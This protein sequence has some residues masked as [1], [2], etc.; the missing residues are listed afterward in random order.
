MF[1]RITFP[2]VLLTISKHFKYFKSRPTPASSH[3]MAYEIAGMELGRHSKLQQELLQQTP[4]TNT[5]CLEATA[6]Q[7]R[8]YVP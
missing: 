1:A 7:A 6:Q 2:G 4:T 5:S 3:S 8:S